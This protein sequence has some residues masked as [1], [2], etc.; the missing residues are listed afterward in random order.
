V[1]IY[2]DEAESVW[3]ILGELTNNTGQD[4]MYI[5]LYASFYDGNGGEIVTDPDPTPLL[6]LVLPDGVTASFSIFLDSPAAPAAYSISIVS[7]LAVLDTR[8]DLDWDGEL[9][10]TDNEEAFVSGSITNRGSVLPDGV[11]EVLVTCYD[12]DGAVVAVGAEILTVVMSSSQTASF[13]IFV[14]GIIPA[15]DSFDVLVLGH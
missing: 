13:S 6:A 14:D 10:L 9:M 1:C 15:I 3:F 7:D 2:Y 5:D 12:R 11:A 4:Q 8:Q